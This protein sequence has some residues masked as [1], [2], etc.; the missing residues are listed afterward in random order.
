MLC[1]CNKI[2]QPLRRNN[3]TTTAAAVKPPAVLMSAR[4]KERCDKRIGSVRA[5]A[6]IAQDIVNILYIHMKCVNY[7]RAVDCCLVVF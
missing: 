5:L 3:V 2:S 7:L 1:L 4:K 6:P